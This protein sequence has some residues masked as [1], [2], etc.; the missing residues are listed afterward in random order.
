MLRGMDSG[1][2]DF[3]TQFLEQPLVFQS[4]L[5]WDTTLAP[6]GDSLAEEWGIVDAQ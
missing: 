6:V 3:A 4:D 5:G 1:P 2:L